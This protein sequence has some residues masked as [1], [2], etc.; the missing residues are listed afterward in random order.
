MGDLKN[1]VILLGKINKKGKI[2]PTA[3]GFL[4]KVSNIIHLVTAKHVIV[5]PKNDTFIDGDLIA[6]LNSNDGNIQARSINDIKSNL[7][8][9]GYF[10]I[11][12]KL[13]SG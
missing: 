3:T 9:V 13:M 4:V 8:F 11:V 1:T 10:T 5:N 7:A 6:F 12:K 2:K